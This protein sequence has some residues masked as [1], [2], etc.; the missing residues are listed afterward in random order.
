MFFEFNQTAKITGIN[1]RAELH[2][3]DP[4]PA[5][6][7]IFEA[8]M[9]NTVLNRFAPG[10]LDA[11]YKQDENP[12]LVD[13]VEEAQGLRVLRFP[14]M[15]AFKWEFQGTGYKL[16][17]DY[18]LGDDE[19]NI[20]LGDITID[21]FKLEPQQGGSVLVRWRTVAHP[22]EKDIGK[23]YGLIQR[24][25]DLVLTPPEPK[26]VGELFGDAPKAPAEAEEEAEE[27][28]A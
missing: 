24:D 27:E 17:V 3:E 5:C 15:S 21:K 12:D 14:G 19:S 7:I 25:V 18:G 11:I 22:T 16:T 2:G 4:K 13:Q 6:D 8:S 20:K 10:L 28:A 26:T 23:L 1:P 9:A